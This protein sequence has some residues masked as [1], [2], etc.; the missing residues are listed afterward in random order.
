[1]EKKNNYIKS[2][3]KNYLYK[4]FIGKLFKK[5][6]ELMEKYEF[7]F[8]DNILEIGCGFAPHI[9]YVKH[10]F[11]NY[12]AV[13]LPDV[14]KLSS[15]IK[16]Y[17]KKIKF[18]YYDGKKLNFPNNYFDRV[19]I[20]HTLEH[21]LEPEKFVNEVL[22]VL[23]KKKILTIALPCDPGISWRIGRFFLKK[24]YFKK[25]KNYEYT[26]ATEHINSIFNLHVI[27]NKKFNVI[28]DLFYPFN[29]NIIDLNLFYI[30]QIK[31]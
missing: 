27:L 2:K 24:T 22:R 25:N 21:I 5:N 10:K 30:C 19:I 31:K 6:H 8:A 14:K 13:D 9:N 11:N 20:S 3:Y 16:N 17:Y 4:G 18:Q 28:K 26:M 1:M 23:K 29:I 12:Y 7:S 15:E